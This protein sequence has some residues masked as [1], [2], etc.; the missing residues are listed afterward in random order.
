MG[1]RSDP[2]IY[3]SFQFHTRP[4]SKPGTL[5]RL[6]FLDLYP[7][8]PGRFGELLLMPLLRSLLPL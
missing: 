8:P 7:L 5:F 2:I 3:P 6:S 4:L 1:A